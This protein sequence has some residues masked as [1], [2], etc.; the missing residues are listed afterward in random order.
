MVTSLVP[1]LPSERAEIVA[2]P[3]ATPVTRPEELTVAMVV[4]DDDHATVRFESTFPDPSRVVAESWAVCPTTM[5]PCGVETST[6]ATA[7]GPEESP[8]HPAAKA[9]AAMATSAAVRRVLGIGF[10][11]RQATTGGR[12]APAIV[13]SDR[14]S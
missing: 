1:V 13:E 9:S 11:R 2:D 7:G 5:S 3:G 8:P 10:L 6:V 14:R 12:A 4:L